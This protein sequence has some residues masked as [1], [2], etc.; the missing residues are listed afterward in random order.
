MTTDIAQKRRQ[1]A[2]PRRRLAGR[3]MVYL[4]LGIL[5]I[6]CVFPFYTMI[7][8]AT[9]SNSDIASGM[10]L[11]PGDQLFANYERLVSSV[12][13]WQGFLNS[14]IITVPSTVLALYF[15]ALAAFGFSRFQFRGKNILFA[16]VLATMMVPTQLGIVG[17]FRLVSSFELLDT[18]W[19]L[20]L[21]SVANAFGVFFLKQ[22]CDTAIPSSILEAARIDGASELR[23]FHRIVLPMLAPALATFG[24]FAFIS[25]WNEFINPLVLIFDAAKQPLPVMVAAAKGQFA[26]DYGAQYV[27][28]T[29]A[30][31]PILIVFI[32]ASRKLMENIGMGAIKE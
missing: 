32:I 13:I 7:I 20:I 18:Y 25:K 19:P 17:F 9:H 12:P 14:L 31:I 21:P 5:S 28:I 15:S 22:F 1:A 4:F 29:I 24:I 23:I 2:P 30:V 27:G 11:L 3:A 26:T 8:S 10:L 6:A 16:A